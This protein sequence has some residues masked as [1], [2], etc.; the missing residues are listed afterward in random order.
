MRRQPPCTCAARPVAKRSKDPSPGN[1]TGAA[2]HA[3]V[4]HDST[5]DATLCAGAS[6]L[7]T[8]CF[9]NSRSSWHLVDYYLRALKLIANGVWL[10]ETRPT[11]VSSCSMP[12][13]GAACTTHEAELGLDSVVLSST[14]GMVTSTSLAGQ[15][16]PLTQ[17]TPWPSQS[18]TRRR[19]RSHRCP[20]ARCRLLIQ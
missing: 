8:G 14:N 16:R 1:Y 9:V 12:L 17:N 2:N 5:T 18:S 7:L 19:L 11:E 15:D 10:L 20:I 3:H 13:L 4:A 6:Q